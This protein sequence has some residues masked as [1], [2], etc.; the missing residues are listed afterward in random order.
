MANNA[1]PGSLREYIEDVEDG[2]FAAGATNNPAG[3]RDSMA[4]NLGRDGDGADDGANDGGGGNGGASASAGGAS[5]S[6]SDTYDARAVFRDG[7]LRLR[8]SPEEARQAQ[9][10]QLAAGL[11]GRIQHTDE[12]AVTAVQCLPAGLCADYP[13]F[14]PEEQA[15]AKSFIRRQ[16]LARS[17]YVR[18]RGSAVTIEGKAYVGT[19]SAGGTGRAGRTSRS[20]TVV[21]AGSL[22]KTVRDVNASFENTLKEF[23]RTLS[24]DATGLDVVSTPLSSLLDKAWSYNISMNVLPLMRRMDEMLQS[25]LKWSRLALPVALVTEGGLHIII[26]E[27]ARR[28]SERRMTASAEVMGRMHVIKNYRGYKDEDLSRLPAPIAA[29]LRDSSEDLQYVRLL[30]QEK[31]RVNSRAEVKELARARARYAARVSGLHAAWIERPD[32]D[33]PLKLQSAV[34]ATTARRSGPERDGVERK[35]LVAQM[36]EV[37]RRKILTHIARLFHES[38]TK[39]AMASLGALSAPTEAKAAEASATEAGATEADVVADKTAEL[40]T[41]LGWAKNGLGVGVMGDVTSGNTVDVRVVMWILWCKLARCVLRRDASVTLTSL[42]LSETLLRSESVGLSRECLRLPEGLGT[43]PLDDMTL[44]ELLSVMRACRTV[45]KA[46]GLDTHPTLSSLLLRMSAALGSFFMDCLTP[47]RVGPA[48]MAGVFVQ[49][50]QP[51]VFVFTSRTAHFTCAQ[52]MDMWHD[53]RALAHFDA[54]IPHASG[55]G[56]QDRRRT[57]LDGFA[58]IQE[59]VSGTRPA[60]IA[61]EALRPT[62]QQVGSFNRWLTQFGRESTTYHTACWGTDVMN[63]LLHPGAIT[64]FEQSRTVRAA[65]SASAGGHAAYDPKLDALRASPTFATYEVASD[66]L[67]TADPETMEYATTLIRD[68]LPVDVLA[69]SS[70]WLEPLRGC[71]VMRF[72]DALMTNLSVKGTAAACFVRLDELHQHMSITNA[73]IVDTAKLDDAL[74]VVA[75]VA[76]GSLPGLE[77]AMC[78]QST[79]PVVVE[80]GAGRFS[81]VWFGTCILHAVDAIT[82]WATWMHL[83]VTFMGAQ[84]PSGIDVSFEFKEALNVFTTLVLPWSSASTHARTA[85]LHNAASAKATSGPGAE[86]QRSATDSIRNLAAIARRRVTLTVDP[87]HVRHARA[88]RASGTIATDAMLARP[89]EMPTEPTPPAAAAAAAAVATAAAVVEDESGESGESDESDESDENDVFA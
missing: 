6:A 62:P 22:L 18:W 27:R 31:L 11:S 73:A 32:G 89:I 24:S 21:F 86:A 52:M 65:R 61:I 76:E 4:A 5:G 13:H 79:L 53:V 84:L 81:V 33:D 43:T 2:A 35:L 16:P 23:S 51:D 83:I 57:L 48:S 8:F 12:V 70:G 25:R 46:A 71:T 78:T 20:G 75:S 85:A 59:I 64:A 28:V 36:V 67:K 37:A 10:A 49:E 1:P 58:S 38:M 66:I 40:R 17:L 72:V 41:N 60:P 45:W 63:R 42:G 56:T 47:A 15:V 14:S 19:G 82:A 3:K 50:L 26:D 44:F 88:L 55:A 80:R 54:A 9:A 30:L 87:E 7:L 34:R 29:K 39:E 69:L 77:L 68:M 74:T